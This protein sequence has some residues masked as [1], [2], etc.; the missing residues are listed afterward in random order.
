MFYLTDVQ[1]D[2]SDLKVVLYMK[3]KNDISSSTRYSFNPCIQTVS[4]SLLP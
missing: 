4:H 3:T 2:I 1:R